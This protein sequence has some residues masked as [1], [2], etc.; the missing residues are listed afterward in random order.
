LGVDED[1]G[2][3]AMETHARYKGKVDIGIK[4]PIKDLSDF[5]YIYTPGVA[6]PSREIAS[7]PESAYE[8]TNKG[9]SVAILTDGSRILGLGNLGPAAALPVMEGKALLFKYLGG[10]DAFPLCVQARTT[11]ELADVAK[12][13]APS[14]GGINMEDVESP[15]CFEVYDLLIDSLDI[16][17]FHDDR[18]G[19]ATVVLAGLIN[20]LKVVGKKLS[21]VSI[22]VVGA[23]AG[24]LASTRLLLRAGAS[25]RNVVVCDSRGPLYEGRDHMDKYKNEVARL[26]NAERLQGTVETALRGVDVMICLSRPG[27]W[28]PKEWVAKMAGDAIVFALANP[29]PEIWPEDAIKGGARVVATGRS[30][31]PNQINNSLAF[32]SIFRGMLE[33][34]ARRVNDEMLIAASKAIANWVEPR[35]GANRI[36]PTMDE[37]EV[38]VKAAIAVAN[39]AMDTGVARIKPPQNELRA[40]IERKIHLVREKLS[41]LME[42][43]LI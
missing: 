16:P 2:R 35:L 27:P 33:V 20:S 32:P 41:I 13:V 11:E 40:G 34:R 9:N 3:K 25:G 8:L 24:G 4:V 28:I 36:V 6:E 22:V 10:V 30:D 7:S 18:Q 42:R 12:K 26:T 1:T 39:A 38:F 5:N 23:G 14:F 43:G 29:T 31:F 37:T 17:V 15:K 19:T 21:Q